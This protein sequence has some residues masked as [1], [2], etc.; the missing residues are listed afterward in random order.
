MFGKACATDENVWETRHD[1]I[2]HPDYPIKQKALALLAAIYGVEPRDAADAHFLE[3]FVKDVSA[4]LHL[5]NMSQPGAIIA[6][7]EERRLRYCRAGT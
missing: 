4:P 2:P 7:V 1:D 5:W 6:D 3:R